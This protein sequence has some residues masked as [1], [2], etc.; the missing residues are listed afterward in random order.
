M[1]TKLEHLQK[2]GCKS[3]DDISCYLSGERIYGDDFTQ[4][5]IEAWYR[6]EENGYAGLDHKDAN[7]PVYFY[8]ALNLLHGFNF[9][10]GKKFEKVLGIGSAYGEEFK[11]VIDHIDNLTILDASKKYIRNKIYGIPV[12][13]Q[14]PLPSGK[15]VFN[16]GSFD[17]ITCLGVLHHIPN[18]SFVMSELHRCL[19]PGGYALIREP[20]VSMGDWTRFRLG[21]TKRERGIPF[22]CF[23]ELI[24]RN[25]FEVTRRTFCVFPLVA[26]LG[27]ILGI[28]VYNSLFL[29]SLDKALSVITQRNRTY[30]RRTLL[31][32]FG[33]T[34]IYY[35]LRKKSFNVSGQI[36]PVSRYEDDNRQ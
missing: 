31:Q 2:T 14:Q 23:N 36:D 32:K 9:L 20:I 16:D 3:G 11:P 24:L 35:V 21:L 26:K 10:P 4:E 33:P 34:N 30:H 1:K 28:K 7:E 22:D 25:G 29:T 8:H 6:D 13:Y 27:S 5:E 12:T 15:L 17:L 19:K 18:V